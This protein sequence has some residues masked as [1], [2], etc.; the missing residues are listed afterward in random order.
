M[1]GTPTLMNL[2]RFYPSLIL[3]T[4]TLPE[5]QR[6]EEKDV[7]EKLK[8]PEFLE[9]VYIAS[10]NLYYSITNLDAL[11]AKDYR[12]TLFSAAKYILR[13]SGRCTPFGLFSG[14]GL[15]DWGETTNLKVKSKTSRTTR[16]DMS[17]LCSIQKRLEVDISV[18]KN[19]KYFPNSS[20]YRLGGEL[21]YVEYSQSSGKRN[22]Q[23]SAIE[24][25][26]LIDEVFRKIGEGLTFDQAV[27]VIRNCGFEKDESEEFVQ[28]LIE[29]QILV[30]ELE[31]SA[32]GNGYFEKILESASGTSYFDPLQKL[33]EL[34][35]RLDQRKVNVEQNFKEIYDKIEDLGFPY[36]HKSLFQVTSF[37]DVRGTVNKSHEDELLEVVDLLGRCSFLKTSNSL[38]KFAEEFYRRYEE[39]EIPLLEVLDDEIGIGFG[40]NSDFVAPLLEG[41]ISDKGSLKPDLK[42]VASEYKMF[43]DLLRNEEYEIPLIEFIDCLENEVS[44][45]PTYSLIFR[46]LEKNKILF[47]MAGG[48]SALNLSARFAEA[49][50]ELRQKLNKIAEDE[51][52]SSESVLAE[53]VHFPQEKVGNIIYRPTFRKHEI[54]FLAHSDAT[55]GSQIAARDLMVSVEGGHIILRDKVS[56]RS[57]VPRLSN[58]HNFAFQSLPLYQ[59]L[60]ELQTQGFQNGLQFGWPSW[61]EEFPFLPQVTHKNVIVKRAEWN[62]NEDDIL[63]IHKITSIEKFEAWRL[64]RNIPDKVIIVEGDNELVIFFHSDFMLD[65]F[66][67]EIKSKKKV[68]L[69]EY[70][71]HSGHI[72]DLDSKKIFANQMVGWVNSG[73]RTKELRVSKKPAGES[74]KRIWDPGSEWLYFKLYCSEKTADKIL[75]NTIYPLVRDLK[76]KELVNIWHFVRFNDPDPHLRI[77]FL[78][79]SRE[80]FSTVMGEVQESLKDFLNERFV[81]KVQLESYHRELERYGARNIEIAEAIHDLDSGFISYLL[82]QFEGDEREEFR[83]KAAIK[84]V[85]LYLSAF[86]YTTQQK[87]ELAERNRKALL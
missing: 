35:S 24:E 25:N 84:M 65:L 27:L 54:P 6:L 60:G 56:G 5:I 33:Q 39:E 74:V 4:P 77:R 68:K 19:L 46:V 86:N 63:G 14:V 7:L 34:L 38:G 49:H 83:W 20:I 47:E 55:K 43:Q 23:V 16:F 59:F 45:A 11:S 22:Y 85:D 30:S 3:R 64:K 18:K 32:T 67:N 70:L 72:T 82:S 41:V 2:T 69:L 79:K 62:L 48:S 37:Q 51:Q 58:A 76:S 71:G 12:N 8:E 9:A 57:V 75:I 10:P 40:N 80:D 17:F 1:L 15:C 42:I 73:R 53:I 29:N 66:R 52:E 81:Q 21:R 36:S 50:E 28:V 31:P 44:L 87:Y 26:E 61:A 78:I 13:A